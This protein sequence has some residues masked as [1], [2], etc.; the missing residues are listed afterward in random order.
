MPCLRCGIGVS[1]YA[2]CSFFPVRET[3]GDALILFF[4][5][6]LLVRRKDVQIGLD[7]ISFLIADVLLVRIP[8]LLVKRP[9]SVRFTVLEFVHSDF[10]T[11][12]GNGFSTRGPNNPQKLSVPRRIVFK[13]SS[14]H[15][16]FSFVVF[17]LDLKQLTTI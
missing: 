16:L 1:P 2:E 11:A 15:C 10:L 3:A 12:F 6:R 7:N 17:A 4:F 5:S 8:F 13:L 9:M 14:R